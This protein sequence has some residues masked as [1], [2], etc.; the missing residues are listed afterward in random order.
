MVA[1]N[2]NQKDLKIRLT[3]HALI[4]LSERGI[5]E[6]DVDDMVHSGTRRREEGI[7][8]RG[9][10]MW[11]FFKTLRGRPMVAVTEVLQPNCFVLT[12]KPA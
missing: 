5:T 9:G 2:F 7:G 10:E 8:E 12:V 3:M 11:L 6:A 1:Y 4:R